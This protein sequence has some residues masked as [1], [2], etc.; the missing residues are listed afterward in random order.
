MKKVALVLLLVVLAAMVAPAQAADADI[1]VVTLYI[2]QV[3]ATSFGYRIDY[4]RPNSL[5][6]ATAYLPLDWFGGTDSVARLVYSD[7]RAIPFINVF[8]E[9][10]EI[11]HV[12]LYVHRSQNHLSWGTI[13]NPENLAANFELE[14]PEF[15]F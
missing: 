2:E 3:Y 12:V 6:M 4:R 11:S 10:G 1:Y 8:F 5:M 7:D 14:Q 13:P 15:Q 9:D